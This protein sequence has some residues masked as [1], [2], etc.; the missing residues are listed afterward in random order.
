VDSLLIS[1]I[2][3]GSNGIGA[4]TVERLCNL[5]AKVVFGDIQAEAAEKQAQKLSTF[6][7]K[8]V[9]T[10]VTKYEDL[11]ALFDTAL[12]TFRKVDCAIS[13]AGVV[14]IGNWVDPDLDLESIKKAC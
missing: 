4:A 5:G 1:P 7:V 8:F 11:I 13:N 9:R 6:P 2:S 10:D 3:G 12:K 14:E